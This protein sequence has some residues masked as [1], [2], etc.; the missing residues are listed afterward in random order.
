MQKV[1]VEKVSIS[2]PAPKNKPIC[3]RCTATKASLRTESGLDSAWMQPA[4]RLG[5]M[6]AL[7]RLIEG[8]G[9]LNPV[10]KIPWVTMHSLRL[11]WLHIADQGITPVFLGGLLH[12]M[13]SDAGIG[14]NEDQRCRW[15]WGQ[16]QEFYRRHG[17]VDKLYD[18]TRTMI[19][20]KKGSIELS[21]SA[22]QIRALVPFG[23]ELVESLV[24]L[25]LERA[26]AKTCMQHL[27]RCYSFLSA[28]VDEGQA[29]KEDSQVQVGIIGRR[30]MGAVLADRPIA[31]VVVRAPC[32]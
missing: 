16:I 19:K 3:W 8:G 17:T 11:D 21:G 9:T 13:L 7:V 22:A 5:H 25:D 1:Y 15:L 18:L 2:F 14:R 20:P 27:S 4:S 31:E 32:R 28:N 6:D 26:A 30:A 23:L 29:S 10:F 12:L 24:E